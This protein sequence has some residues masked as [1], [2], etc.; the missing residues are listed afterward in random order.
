MNSY[1]ALNDQIFSE[2]DFKIVPIRFEDRLDILK[3]RNEQVYHLRQD[4]PLT[5]ENQEA[6]FSN[7]VSKLFEQEQP[8]QLLFSFLEGDRCIGYGGLVHIN[9]IDKNAEISFIMNT[10]LEKELF[11]SHWTTYLKL[12]EKL[13]FDDLKLHKIFTYAFDIRPHLYPVFENV[14]FTKDAVLK[15]HCYFDG[16]Y[17]D[18]VIHSK[19]KM[20]EETLEIRNANIKDVDLLFRWSN[21]ELVRKQSFVSN[22]IPYEGHCNWYNAKLE[23]ENSIMFILEINAI[24]AGVVRF[25][26]NEESATI[27]ISIDENFRGKGFGQTFIELGVNEYFIEN[28]LPVLASIKKD[29]I[30]SIKSFVKAGFTF[31]REEEIKGVE[32]SVYQLK[33]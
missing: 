6:Y 22:A 8:N 31:F 17:K 7:V 16:E 19:I 33:K 25:D 20:E 5:V 32:T 27:G 3:W 18:V 2:N 1:K 13:A 14:G 12:I 29:N 10:S 28:E 15:D 21:D 24:P 11:K 4:K 30:A 23:D 26:L 9:W